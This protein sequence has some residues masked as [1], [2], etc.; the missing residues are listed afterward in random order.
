ME[1]T[2]RD[3]TIAMS[4]YG[5]LVKQLELSK[6]ALAQQTPVIQILDMPKYP[7]EDNKFKFIVYLLVGILTGLVLSIG[8]VVI[9]YL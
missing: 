5:E 6:W 8:V 2:Q 9:K 3:K 1:L 7:L 4:I